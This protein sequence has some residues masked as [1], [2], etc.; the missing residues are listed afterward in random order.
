MAKTAKLKTNFIYNLAYQILAIILPLI[1]APYVTRVL[2]SHNT[3]VYSYTQA[4]ANYFYLFA[5][6]GVN[7][8][9]NRTIASVRDDPE[10]LKTNFWEIYVFQFAL[11]VLVNVCYLLYCLFFVGED[12]LVYYM[13]F[14]YVA[15]AVF[16]INWLCFGL[17]QFRL[18]TVRNIIVRVGMAAAV[19]LFVR[20][21]GDL[22]VYTAIIAGGS[23]ISVLVVWPFVMKHVPFKLPTWKGIVRHIKPNL[24]LFWPVVAVSLYHIMDK[25]MLGAM[26]TKD[27]VS[28]YTY[29]ENIVQIPNTLILALDNV[30]MPRMSNLYANH[31]DEK[32]L[33]LFKAVMAFAMLAAAAMSFG[34][35]GV[36]PVFAPWF[37][38]VDFS[39]CG[40]Y[41]ALLSPIIVF[42][43]WAG[44]LR[45]QYIIPKKKEKIY[46]IS[47]STGAVVNLILNA[48]LIP[49]LAGAGAVIGTIAAEF[50]VCFLQ[51]L[52]IRKEIPIREF[53]TNGFSFVLIGGIMYALIRLIS[54]FGGTGV[55]TMAIQVAA[56]GTLYMLLA[57]FYMIKIRHE[58]VL[59]NE[60]LK[61]LH[62]KYRFK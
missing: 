46:I 42:K 8:Y 59:F 62:V 26:S 45:T 4:F 27:E 25:L 31:Q 33:K 30:M 7:N 22:P 24:V 28:F 58:P 10:K 32:A 47:L 9:G 11:G 35:M 57:A 15:S 54:G 18:T 60:G 52:L 13:Q 14:F 16:S 55:L 29:A 20:D 34:L 19:F 36:G 3:G 39:R 48:L 53:M 61:L 38:G 41:I 6:L 12:T 49:K 44:A 50:S 1:T 17:E 51:F 21:K 43:G 37:Y 23:L 2:G 56:G 5:M 40:L